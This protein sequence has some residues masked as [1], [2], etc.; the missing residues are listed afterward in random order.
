MHKGKKHNLF[1]TGRVY[2]YLREIMGVHVR[3]EKHSFFL[4]QM[5]VGFINVFKD[6]HSD[7]KLVCYIY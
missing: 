1:V 2:G 7:E 5:M 6:R 4:L 3:E